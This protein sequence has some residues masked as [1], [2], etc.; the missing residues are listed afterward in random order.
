MSEYITKASWLVLALIHLTPALVL[1]S[2]DLVQKLYGISASDDVGILIV[3]RG[4]LF[5][6]VL[7]SILLACFL[8]DIRRLASLITAISVISFLYVYSRAGLPEGP[9]RKI[10]VI[11]GFAL[12]PLTW[13]IW[14]SWV[15]QR[16]L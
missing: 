16:P 13:V 12:L 5:L 4:G 15:V 2:P 14:Q 1:F 8:T 11:D 9:L 7:V 3:H 6:A 10:A